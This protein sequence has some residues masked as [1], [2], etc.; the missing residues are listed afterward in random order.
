M[1]APEIQIS[2]DGLRL[3]YQRYLADSAA[4]FL[5]ILIVLLALNKGVPLPFLGH[6]LESLTTLSKDT[7]VFV[8]L[9]TFLLATPL[10]L[11]I[12]GLSWFFLGWCKL[13][14]IDIWLKSPEKY[15]N[16]F[17]PTK[18]SFRYKKLVTFFFNNNQLSGK[19]Y[20]V[21]EQYQ[22]YLSIFFKDRIR[23]EHVTGLSQFARNVSF[24]SVCY[25]FI[26]FYK[27]S[28]CPETTLV[29]SHHFILL[30]ILIAILAAILY[31]LLESFRCLKILSTIHLLCIARGITHNTSDDPEKLIKK[32]HAAYFA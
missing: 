27:L 25:V 18:K 20:E 1:P 15:F 19:I 2:K 31:S 13:Y 22:D 16:P 11:T 6:S 30:G 24:I 28:W 3:S 32:I 21:S 5:V 4:G 10:G 14:S 26:I 29:T 8:F 23:L 7:K 9:I 17:F 12:N